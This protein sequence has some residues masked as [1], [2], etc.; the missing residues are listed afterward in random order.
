MQAR[1]YRARGRTP[2]R[3]SHRPLPGRIG[4]TER[5]RD[6]LKNPAF[7]SLIHG[8]DCAIRSGASPVQGHT[9]R[10]YQG[11][12]LAGRIKCGL[13]R[14]L[15]RDGIRRVADAAG[16][17]RAVRVP[18]ERVARAGREPDNAAPRNPHRSR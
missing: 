15:E 11:P 8:R 2:P 4:V 7:Q 3:P 1:F 13:V 17:A 6:A 18:R 9:T 16:V 14:L 10:V 5:I 12:D